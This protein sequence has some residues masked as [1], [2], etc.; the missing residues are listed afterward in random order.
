MK[1]IAW[2]EKKCATRR[3]P[4]SRDQPISGTP[5]ASLIA[6]PMKWL[7]IWLI[8]PAVTSVSGST[9]AS[10]MTSASLTAGDRPVDGLWAIWKA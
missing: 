3:S 5:T 4:P 6:P 9:S 7:P 10:P 1:C 8:V 2:V